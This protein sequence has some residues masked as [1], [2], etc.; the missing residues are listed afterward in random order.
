MRRARQDHAE[1]LPVRRAYTQPTQGAAASATGE[2]VSTF[3]PPDIPGL[4]Y[5]TGGTSQR[6]G[7]EV[8]AHILARSWGWQDASEFVETWARWLFGINCARAQVVP[9]IIDVD[10]DP[11]LYTQ[12]SL[13]YVGDPVTAAEPDPA[14]AWESVRFNVK[15]SPTGL[16]VRNG[17]LF[18]VTYYAEEWPVQ[19]TVVAQLLEYRC[20]NTI[21]CSDRRCAEEGYWH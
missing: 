9:A 20:N 4:I 8:A 11:L 15:L 17:R 5:W 14:T 10:M 7:N 12:D 18:W 6:L 1:R 16:T 3:A 21:P 13:H 2:A 19:E